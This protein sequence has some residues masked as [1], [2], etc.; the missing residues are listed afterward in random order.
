VGSVNVTGTPSEPAGGEPTGSEPTAQ[1]SDDRAREGSDAE[2]RI[3][4]PAP[5]VAEGVLEH[6]EIVGGAQVQLGSN[7]TFLVHLNARHESAAPGDIGDGDTGPGEPAVMRAI[8][9][10]RDGERPL[11]DYPDGTLYLRE[12]ATYLVAQALGWPKVPLTVIRDGPFGPG[13]MQRF[14]NFDP[15]VTYFNLR[16][17][18]LDELAPFA[19]FDLLVNNGDRK[20]GHFLLD[21]DDA[22]WSVDHGL[23]FHQDFK[24]RTVMLEFWDEP[25]P[26]ALVSDLRALMSKLELGGELRAALADLISGPELDALR[27]R[28]DAMLASPVHPMLD[29]YRNVPWPLI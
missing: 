6:G 17:D 14:V 22:I 4:D 1:S 21:G 13:S 7:Q 19:T 2:P 8:Y 26:D 16:E 5:E 9:K 25:I 10:P 15:G 24:L 11:S 3:V 27:A 20:G 28:L 29:P 18:R 23:T 12:Y